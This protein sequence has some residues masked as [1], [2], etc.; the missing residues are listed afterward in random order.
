MVMR[1]HTSPVMSWKRQDASAGFSPRRC[2]M[3]NWRVWHGEWT[4]AC[5]R[6]GEGG[7]DNL[8]RE[9]D[10]ISKM[11]PSFEVHNFV[12]SAYPAKDARA[13]LNST[14]PGARGRSL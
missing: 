11:V 5:G 7:R 12:V 1:K 13:S 4:G 14:G 9:N 8:E 2:E 6:R 10:V 3:I